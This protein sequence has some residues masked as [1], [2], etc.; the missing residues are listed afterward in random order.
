[1]MNDRV[2][3]IGNR[4]EIFVDHL[5]IEELKGTELRLHEPKLMPSALSRLPQAYTTVIKDGGRY[6]A[7]YRD[8]LAGS[9]FENAQPRQGPPN[10]D[11]REERA[12]KSAAE[13]TCYAESRDGHEWSFPNLDFH[14]A[15]SPRGSNVILSGTTHCCHNFTPF[16]DEREGISAEQRFKGLC[17]THTN[18]GGLHALVSADGLHWSALQDT[19]VFS[20]EKLVT[21]TNNQ[22]C[23][24]L[25]SQNPS[26][27]S[28]AEQQYVCYMRANVMRAN[29]PL[30]AISRIT[31]EDFIH[32]SDPILMETGIPNEQLYTSGTHPYFRSPHIYIALPTRFFWERG[33]STDIVFMA[34]RAGSTQYERLFPEAYI[35]PGF[36]KGG[37]ANR[38]NY[39]ALNVVPTS[40]TEMSI[41]N[42]GMHWGD[43]YTLRIDGFISI[44]AGGRPGE[45]LTTPLTFSGEKLKIN[46]STSAAGSVLLEIQDLSGRALPGFSLEDCDPLIGNSIEQ[47]VTWKTSAGVGTLAGQTVRLRFVLTDCDLYAF[48]FKTAED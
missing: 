26:F 11:P 43:H 44:R 41:Y 24:G 17:G 12:R 16:V 10:G 40:A 20:S 45:F 8:Y 34:T 6:R 46:Y 28:E 18:G 25:D 4:W 1:M 37:W 27:W 47:E 5:I 33:S 2:V 39:A 23:P 15:K 19:P 29:G 48:G 36:D 13:I 21:L 3:D 32:W 42:C 30:R 31:S 9:E 14:Q 35:R 22:G 38:A 7:Y